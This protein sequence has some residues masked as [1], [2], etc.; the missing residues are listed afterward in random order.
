MCGIAGIINFNKKDNSKII[1]AM[2]ESINFR[3]PDYKTSTSG[4]F[5]DVG[6]VRLS[7]LDLSNNGNQPF[8]S[9]DKKIS[10]I[11]NGE[12]YNFKELKY[13]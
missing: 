9:K 7:I 5:Y 2:L 10:V 1:D 11:Y 8:L 3:G 13:D 12:I 4:E 6:M